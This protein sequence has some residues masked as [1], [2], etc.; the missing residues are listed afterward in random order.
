MTW[1][2]VDFQTDSG[3]D[4]TLILAEYGQQAMKQVGDSLRSK[5]EWVIDIFWQP[6]SLEEAITAAGISGDFWRT[7]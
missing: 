6:A 4:Y 5:G 3:T 2:R 1:Y 7:N